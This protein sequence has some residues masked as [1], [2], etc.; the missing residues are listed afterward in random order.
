M[1]WIGFKKL[2]EKYGFAI[3]QPLDKVTADPRYTKGIWLEKLLMQMF[4]R[5]KNNEN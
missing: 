3:S 4:N 5:L 1:T 2:K